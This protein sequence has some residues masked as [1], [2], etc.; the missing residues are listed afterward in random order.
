MESQKI[1]LDLGFADLVI[2]VYDGGYPVPEVVI[3]LN[4]G[5]HMQDIAVVRQAINEKNSRQE[6]VECLIYADE[7]NEDYTN[8]Y[9]IKKHE[10]EE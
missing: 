3:Y 10:F 2:E 4:D 6:A 9:I 7:T 8:K 1:K 5:Q